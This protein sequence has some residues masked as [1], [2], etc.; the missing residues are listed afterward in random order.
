MTRR[1]GPLALALLALGCMQ[2]SV[3][4]AEDN[5]ADEAPSYSK[6]GADTCLNCHGGDPA[7]MGVFRTRHAQPGDPRTP[8]GHGQLQ[9]E[10]CHGPGGAH[11]KRPKKGEQRTPVVQFGRGKASTIAEQNTMCLGCHNSNLGNWHVAIHND[12]G[13]G[14]ADC[15]KAHDP[16]DP[17]RAK[18]T[19]VEVCKTCHQ[20]QVA[21]SL[22][23]FAHPLHE[24][25]M[26]CSSCHSPHGSLADASLKRDTI[27]ET[28]YTCHADKRGPFLWEHQP[29]SEDC[30]LCHKP[31]GS[32]QAGMLKQRPP[33][34]CQQCHGAQGHPSVPGLPGD[35][36]GGSNPS[37][38]LLGSGC[39][40]CHSQ[41][42][43][44]NHPSGTWLTR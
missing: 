43:G 15:H 19:Q 22:L 9:C 12:N 38:Y 16:R 17:V 2:A 32:A 27:N 44:S 28:C 31:H 18:A 39:A 42:H 40:N 3:A 34:L 37:V 33:F 20:L 5:Q 30:T 35:V 14:C 13:V 11:T 21:D 24:G 36:P 6:N 41:V 23:P 29:V 8:F 4:L 25:Q 7:V 1:L 10:A 26:A